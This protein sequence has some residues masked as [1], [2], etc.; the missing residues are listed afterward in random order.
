LV[1]SSG[2]KIYDTDDLEQFDTSD[3]HIPR[4]YLDR[5]SSRVFLEKR[6]QWKSEIVEVDVQQ[7]REMSQRLGLKA[8]LD[9]LIRNSK[10]QLRKCAGSN[11]L[12][13]P[14]KTTA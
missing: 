10:A 8:L 14:E 6:D 2:R 12:A 3:A 7:L 5:D 13:S 9:E 4:A 1:F 11:P